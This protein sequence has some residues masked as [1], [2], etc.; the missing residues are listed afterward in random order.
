M[1]QQHVLHKLTFQTRGDNETNIRYY[2]RS[3]DRSRILWR[4]NAEVGDRYRG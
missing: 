2:Y 4:P 1:Q 3:R